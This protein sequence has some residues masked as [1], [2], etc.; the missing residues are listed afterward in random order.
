ME[1]SSEG[2]MSDYM[3]P[4]QRSRAMS[5]VKL[6]DGP[7]EKFVQRKLRA[8]GLKFRCHVH[9][10]PGSPDIVFSKEKVA[11]FVDGDF[12]H[13]WRLPA[14]EVKL[15]PFWKKKLCENRKRDQRNFRRL[16]ASGWRVVR[17]W[18]HELAKNPNYCIERIRKS[19][20]SAQSA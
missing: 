14:W 2:T 5:R 7:L 6:K 11:V 9:A 16:R 18:E 19:L 20:K 10:L 1:I 3:T 13:G 15:S 4:E 8:T 12:W 17:I